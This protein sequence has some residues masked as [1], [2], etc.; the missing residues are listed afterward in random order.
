ML[1]AATVTVITSRGIPVKPID[2]ITAP[3]ARKFGNMPIHANFIDLNRKRN[4]IK[5]EIKTI[6]ILPM[7]E[8]NK[9][10]NKLL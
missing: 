2:P 1:T 6:L 3:A 8:P 7:S 9:L 4:I 10:C 5:I